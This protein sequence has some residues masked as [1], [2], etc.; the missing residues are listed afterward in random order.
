VFTRLAK[1]KLARRPAD[2]Y[3]MPSCRTSPSEAVVGYWQA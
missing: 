1:W 2:L 3:E